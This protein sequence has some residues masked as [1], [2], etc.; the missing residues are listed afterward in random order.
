M[1]ARQTVGNNAASWAPVSILLGRLRP[2][3]VFWY[4]SKLS[5]AAIRPL[6]ESSLDR[7]R[8]R[9]QH[10]PQFTS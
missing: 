1:E 2:F 3:L 7:R 9:G 8:H 4:L 5:Q 6:Y 10:E